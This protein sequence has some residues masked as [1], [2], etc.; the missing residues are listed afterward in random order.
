M[1]PIPAQIIVAR[2]NDLRKEF[3]KIEFERITF[4][5]LNFNSREFF[6]KSSIVMFVDDDGRTI[7]LKNR[8]GSNGIV[9]S[10]QSSNHLLK[11]FAI[12]LRKMFNLKF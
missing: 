3:K 10:I 5:C 4:Y 6:Q 9:K 11:R 8:Y 2:R 1:E 7:I 12:S